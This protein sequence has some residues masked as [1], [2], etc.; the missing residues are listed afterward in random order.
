MLPDFLVGAIAAIGETDLTLAQL[1]ALA[2]LADESHLV[3]ELADAL[4]RSLSATS[5]LVEQLV[6]RRLVSRREASHDR[7]SRRVSIAARGR[8]LLDTLM[9]RRAEAQLAL[10]TEL[11]LPEQARVAEGTALLATAARR[12]AQRRRSP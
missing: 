12:R 11:S 5:R 1:A 2:L 6:Q 10:V 7:R 3:S 4:G 9:A 8:R